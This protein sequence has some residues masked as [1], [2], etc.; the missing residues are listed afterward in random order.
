MPRRIAS[1]GDLAK[2]TNE[3]PRRRTIGD[4]DDVSRD[5]RAKRRPAL[6][7]L[8][9]FRRFKG[10]IYVGLELLLLAMLVSVRC[11]L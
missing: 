8:T 4:K 6:L 5:G 2:L 9:G 3:T 11:Y 7:R 10:A 1:T